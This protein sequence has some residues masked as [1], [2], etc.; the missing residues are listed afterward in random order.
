MP[1]FTCTD[2][3]LLRVAAKPRPQAAADRRPTSDES[4]LR[5][6]IRALADDDELLA[7][8][9]HA[10]RPLAGEVAKVVRGEPIRPK[11]LPRIAV[12]LTKYHLRMSTRATPFGLFAG[13]ATVGFGGERLRLG[14]GHEPVSRPDAA[15][16]GALLDTVRTDQA[17]LTRSRLLANPVR[18]VRGSRLVVPERYGED[19][20][21]RHETS[22]RYTRAVR[23]V[24]RE[25]EKPV[26][27]TELLDRF[28]AGARERYVTLLRQLVGAQ[29][30]LTDLDPPPDCAD[31][32]RY[33]LGHPAADAH[34]LF[35]ELRRTHEELHWA[36]HGPADTRRVRASVVADHMRA[37]HEADDVVRTDLRL[38][39]QGGLPTEVAREAER[40][41][42][43]L[44]R[45][46][47]GNGRSRLAGYH[48]RFLERYGSERVVPVTELLNPDQGLGLPP[49]Y[50]G[51]PE[52][53]Q[54]AVHDRRD[55]VLGEL[56]LAAARDR[57]TEVVL[58]DATVGRLAGDH[59]RRPGSMELCVEL[60]G[61]DEDFQLVVGE[62]LGSAMA[63]TTLGRFAHLFPG[64]REALR[65]QALA[66]APE[67]AVQLAFRPRVPRSAN[68]TSAPQWLP[69]RLPLGCGPAAVA[70]SDLTDLSLADLAV[71]ATEDRLYLVDT[72]SGTR[73][74]PVSYSA[75]SPRS[76]H[77]PP[78]ARFLL[79]LGE[80]DTTPCEP[81][82][83]GTWF[84]AP[85]LPRI[86]YG[87]TVLAPARWSPSPELT[88]STADQPRWERCLQE[89]R[90]RWDVPARMRLT[91]ADNRIEVDL[92]DPLHRMVF[93]AEL[94]KSP[95]LKVQEVLAPSGSRA[96]EVVVQLLGTRR[97]A[98]G[99]PP[100]P[101]PCTRV[102]PRRRSD[103]AH[104]PGGEW[105]YAKLYASDPAQRQILR[106]HL[107]ALTGG[108]RLA[109]AGVDSWFY[110]RYLDPDPH[111][112]LRFHGKAQELWT[113]LL[114]RL[115]EWVTTRRESGLLTGFAVDTYDPEVERYGGECAMAAAE[116][117]FHAD[118]R[119]ALSLLRDNATDL[120]LATALSV[121]DLVFRFARPDE[122]LK[123]LESTVTVDERKAVSRQRAGAVSGHITERGIV[124]VV[125][126]PWEQRWQSAERYLRALH[127]DDCSPARIRRIAASLAHMHCNRVLGPDRARE[128]AVY[129]LIRGGLA[130]HVR[131]RR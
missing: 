59:G 15:W 83:W 16:L 93:R 80:Q 21:H 98:P 52:E 27:C 102:V 14:N 130:P 86:R 100:A 24:L 44:W 120:E 12:A 11:A 9:E 101:Q 123:M 5:D 42:D 109:G 53:N 60:L 79:E 67:R 38:D 18:I 74:T 68:V 6:R 78:V 127:V 7:A 76:G 58:D 55:R 22:I 31:P 1:L 40:V 19:G 96:T 81:W 72:A 85:Y 91:V 65:R 118:S 89:W 26:W 103:L 36:D 30:L 35:T 94:R 2:V 33:L 95:G 82:H 75:L 8:V 131:R 129:A 45:L 10:S 48:G 61:D 117:L 114:P 64:Q 51:E 50:Q 62:N 71:G 28:P 122:V 107:P 90:D 105:L 125:P 29:V 92:D 87:R 111:L 39:V 84:D 13:V 115:R 57:R 73:V 3:A 47:S 124:P 32:L 110:V 70:E 121:L 99:T 34:P 113:T 17:V 23:A 104:L 126:A 54:P 56:L 112:R 37:V 97:G 43:L 116:D 46:S 66:G 63:G 41:A 106:D 20:V 25:T 88:A 69:R 128:R 77:I 4:W 108:E 119:V 49:G